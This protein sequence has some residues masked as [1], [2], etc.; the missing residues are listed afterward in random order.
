MASCN[1]LPLAFYKTINEHIISLTPPPVEKYFIYD[2]EVFA[3]IFLCVYC[4]C[5]QPSEKTS[6][7]FYLYT[8]IVITLAMHPNHYVLCPK[9]VISI[10]FTSS[11][12][13]FRNKM[14]IFHDKTK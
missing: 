11:T 12:L 13:K 6:L 4:Y 10:I 5:F 2:W 3:F 7:I 1:P 8:N 9:T 14:A